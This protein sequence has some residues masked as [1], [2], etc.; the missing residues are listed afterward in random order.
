MIKQQTVNHLVYTRDS[1]VFTLILSKSGI[2]QF[3]VNVDNTR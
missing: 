2:A 3:I 1:S